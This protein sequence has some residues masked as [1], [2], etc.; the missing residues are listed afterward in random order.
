[1]PDITWA[2]ILTGAAA[3][4]G[5]AYLARRGQNLAD[6]RDIRELTRLVEEVRSEV[7]VSEEE[8]LSLLAKDTATHVKRFE[9]E[10]PI[11]RE[12]WEKFVAVDGALSHVRIAAAAGVTTDRRTPQEAYHAFEVCVRDLEQTSKRLEPFFSPEVSRALFA[13]SLPLR[14]I[15]ARAPLNPLPA[16][17]AARD[18]ELQAQTKTIVDAVASVR[19]AIR[20]RL[21]SDAI[22]VRDKPPKPES[23]GVAMV[24]RDDA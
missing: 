20:S 6:K 11:Y 16:D 4:L 18:A 3:A 1:M 17:K 19:E 5:G 13:A 7:R 21:H 8:V 10:L 14:L 23:P 15:A 9:I 22:A 24:V 12:L 2:G